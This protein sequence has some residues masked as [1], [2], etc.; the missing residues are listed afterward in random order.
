MEPGKFIYLNRSE[1]ERCEISLAR[2]IEIAEKTYIE[3]AKGAY[4]LPPKPGVHP[5]NCPGAFL[6]AMPGYLPGMDAV[7]LK[8]VAVFGHNRKKHNINSLSSLMI[9]NDVETGYPIAVMEAGYITAV[10]TATASAVAVKHLAKEDS[11][12]MG[13]I[14]AG[15]QGHYNLEAIKYVLPSLKEV[16]VY[17]I[18]EDFAYSFAETMSDKLSLDIRVCKS[19]E[20]V[21]RDSD[22]VV[23]AAP[24]VPEEPIYM[25]EW[26][27]EGVLLLPVHAR[28]WEFD[29]FK[30]ASKFV[31]DDWEQYAYAMFGPG[32]YYKDR[33]G[34][35]P[36]AQLGEVVMGTKVGREDDNEIIVAAN[37]GIALQ[38]ISLGQEILRVSATKNLG[39]TL[40]LYWFLQ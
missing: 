12:V 31:V 22:I 23:A 3:H 1:V 7:G 4:E 36:Y 27:N 33:G 11:E 39:Q 40:S 37:M 18:Y 5:H 20:E 24:I 29:I 2:S 10:R 26:I 6:H 15:E 16:K 35:E 30:N 8:W 19:A 13:V 21:I 17:D 32:R 34:F 9:L 25:K 38:D 28:G 14:G